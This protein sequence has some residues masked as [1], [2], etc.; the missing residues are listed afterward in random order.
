MK[1]NKK[2]INRNTLIHNFYKH[3]AMFYS[4]VRNSFFNNIFLLG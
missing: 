2:K 1:K 3:Y 4:I